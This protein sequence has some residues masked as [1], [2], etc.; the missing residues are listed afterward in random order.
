MI[1]DYAVEGWAICLVT[2]PGTK[3]PLPIVGLFIKDE[4]LNAMIVVLGKYVCR[5]SG[6]CATTLSFPKLLSPP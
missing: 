5:Y 4:G 6:S 2:S 1:A 3:G